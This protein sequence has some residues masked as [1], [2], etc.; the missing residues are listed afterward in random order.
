VAVP[1]RGKVLRFLFVPPRWEVVQLVG[2]QTLDLAILVRVQ[3]SQ[4]NFNFL[5]H[6]LR[7]PRLAFPDE[8]KATEEQTSHFHHF[9]EH[10][11]SGKAAALVQVFCRSERVCGGSLTRRRHCRLRQQCFQMITK[12]A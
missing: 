5:A 12:F 1:I 11:C 9:P 8:K 6:T 4:P 10:H 7:A 3:A 2:L